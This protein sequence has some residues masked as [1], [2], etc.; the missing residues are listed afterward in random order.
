RVLP[1][2]DGSVGVRTREFRWPWKM[3]RDER[4]RTCR[5]GRIASRW[6]G[7]RRRC[8]APETADQPPG[9]IRPDAYREAAGVRARA[10][11]RIFR[12]A[13]GPADCPGR[14][15]ARLSM[16]GVD[17]GHRQEY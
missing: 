4:R 7:F 1:R 6:D 15:V 8:R 2:T 14:S 17:L 5:C 9:R 12:S 16:V 11:A 13:S 3:A 10:R